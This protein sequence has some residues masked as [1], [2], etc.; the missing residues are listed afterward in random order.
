MTAPKALSPLETS[1]LHV[2]SARQPMH[3]GSIGIFEGAP[4]RDGRGRVRIEDI[5]ERIEQR[6]D[7]VPKLRRRIKN[8]VLPGAPPVWVD[9]PRFALSGHV[10]L[11]KLVVPGTDRQFLDM[12]SD[13]FGQLL[14]RSRPL[15]HLCIVD[16]LTGDRV[17][18]IERI[19]HSLADGVAGVEMATVLFDFEFQSSPTV[20][21]GGGGQTW[22]AKAPPGIMREALQDLGRLTGLGWRWAGQGWR[23]TR[24]PI[25][26]LRGTA[27]L[28]GAVATLAGTGML[29]PSTSLNR[30]IGGERTVEVVRE[31]LGPLQNA[32][33]AIGVTM[34]DLVLSAVGG[35]IARL[36]EERGE[37]GPADIQV[38]VPVALGAGDSR[39]L[40]NQVSAWFVRVPVGTKEPLA[41]LHSVSESTRRARTS[42]EELAAEMALDLLAPVPQPVMGCMSRLINHQP[43]FNL[44]VT[45]VPGP[46]S[47]LSMLGARMLEA[48]PFVP[49]AG[50]LTFGVAVL[51][52]DGWLSLGVLADPET[53]PDAAVFARGVEV[54]LA[55]LVTAALA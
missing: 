22:E 48:Y 24:H 17:G 21:P 4:L 32:A 7:L 41:R 55:S 51:S 20:Q 14:D 35:G 5:R 10:E 16:G 43:L 30:T 45:N 49:L 2:E 39:A 37:V 26:T 23:A 15:W 3:I 40:G 6:L 13:L 28:G 53:C 54:E 42:H 36:L 19:H 9:D 18:V 52:Y 8:T 31:P 29:R 50:N 46:P 25:D 27:R 11:V 47:T 34:N 44:I 38:L 33:H 12:C 1:F